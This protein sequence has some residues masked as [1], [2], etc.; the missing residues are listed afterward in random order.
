[1][2]DLH[3]SLNHIRHVTVMLLYVVHLI[4]QSLNPSKLHPAAS[5][6]L[7]KKWLKNENEAK[8]FLLLPPGVSH[9]TSIVL[10]R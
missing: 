2:H 7:T 5:F 1:M 6:R 4:W 3:G 9:N 10:R 8:D